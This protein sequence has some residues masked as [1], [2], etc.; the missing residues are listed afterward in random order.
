MM[1]PDWRRIEAIAGDALE[2][3]GA[4]R[5]AYLDA[6]CGPDQALR[7]EVESP[8]ACDARAAKIL[9]D[10]VLAGAAGFVEEGLGFAP[11]E[12]IGVYRVVREIGRGGMGTVY[13]AERDDEQFQKL[14][15]IKLVTRGMDTAALLDR[16]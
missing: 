1:P 8:L 12:R 6:T 7:R 14:V 16:F 9:A 5:V 13:L 2:R 4:D 11:G 15:A 3:D 10:A